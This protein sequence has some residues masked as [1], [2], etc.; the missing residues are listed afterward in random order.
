MI[1]N[2]SKAAEVLSK[3]IDAA[4]VKH[5]E[6]AYR[7]HLGASQIGNYC[8]RAL[9]YAF[10]WCK[11]SKHDG[12]MHRLF[13][14]GHKE[15]FYFIEYLEWVG[16]KVWQFDP[17]LLRGDEGDD[18]DAKAA[19]QWKISDVDGHFGGSCDGV[20]ECP[21]WF[22]DL[23]GE[24]LGVRVLT[25]FKTANTKSFNKLKQYGVIKSKP[26]HY[27]QMC[28]YGTKLKLDYAIYISVCKET[29][30]LY[31]EIIKVD[32]A[33]ANK[34]IERAVDIIT[35]QAPLQKVSEDPNYFKCGPKWCEFRGICHFGMPPDKNCRS[36]K[37]LIPSENKSWT[38][39][40]FNRRTNDKQTLMGTYECWE[41]I[42]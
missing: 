3:N 17:S 38:C 35:S 16:F 36:C 12:R 10:R 14:R 37:W 28:V 31:I 22:V 1:Q 32:P 21:Q 13:Q 7:S 41:S 6:D 42:T 33:V 23:L 2:L 40:K 39:T 9:W 4:C 5:Y 18:M 11:A 25:E 8:D 34:A 19:A 24:P 30:E 15:E 26:E 27:T 20:A 29:D